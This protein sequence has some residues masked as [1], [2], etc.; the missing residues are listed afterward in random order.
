MERIKIRVSEY[1]EVDPRELQRLADLGAKLIKDDSN[2]GVNLLVWFGK[3]CAYSNDSI[4]INNV[5]LPLS[6]GNEEYYTR[7]I[8][9]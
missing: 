3:K 2:I 9:V 8:E 4:I 5:T 6:K 7:I 1:N